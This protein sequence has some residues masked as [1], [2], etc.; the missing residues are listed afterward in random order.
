MDNSC[1]EL[2]YMAAKMTPVLDC[3][4]NRTQSFIK[5]MPSCTE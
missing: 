1:R 5:T 3:A 2:L 4:L